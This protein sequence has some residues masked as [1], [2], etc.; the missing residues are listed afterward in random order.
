M[1]NAELID[2]LEELT[3]FPAETEWIEFKLGKGSVTDVLC[4]V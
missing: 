3:A 2:L 4:Y 1:T